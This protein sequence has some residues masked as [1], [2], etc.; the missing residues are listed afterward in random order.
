[1]QE[2]LLSGCKSHQTSA[3]AYI[4][5][6]YHGAM[7]YHAIKAI[8]DAKYKITYA[9]LHK[10]LLSML[11]VAMYDQEPQLEGKKANKNRQV[12]T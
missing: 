1:M 3:D 6:D 4:D 8:T 9:E 12:F 5:N 2:I 10:R 11:Q 7:S